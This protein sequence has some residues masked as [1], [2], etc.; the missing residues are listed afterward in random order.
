MPKVGAEPKRRAEVI[1][2]ALTCI[3]QYGI[4]GMTLDKVAEY[5]GC[6]KGVIVY[7]FQNKD[8]LT[9]D[10]FKAFL[11]Y[12]GAKIQAEILPEMTAQEKMDI[13]L[14]HIL[15]VARD[16]E[17]RRIDVSGLEGVGRMTIPYEDQGR[18]FVQ[19]FSKAV[20]DPKLREIVSQSYAA[21]LQGIS[22]IIDSGRRAGQKSVPDPHSAA[23][24]LLAM[25]IGLSFFRVAELQTPNGQDNR[26]ICEDYVRILMTGQ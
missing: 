17:D 13:T 8:G 18:L 26:A 20:L 15:P 25:V 5:A 9:T 3:S 23:Y 11:A 2:A 19:F 7:Y 14:K 24:G 12:Y 21:D 16:V 10:A 6:S 1:N 22:K 4:E